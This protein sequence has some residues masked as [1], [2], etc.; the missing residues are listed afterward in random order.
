MNATSTTLTTLPLN[1]G[2]FELYIFWRIIRYDGTA[3]LLPGVLFSVVCWL[4]ENSFLLNWMSLLP[5]FGKSL[6]Y[7][8]C[9]AYTF[10]LSNQ[11]LGVEEDRKNNKDRPLPKGEISLR[12]AWVRWG[13][14]MAVY[15]LVGWWLDVLLWTLLWQAISIVHNLL[16]G[17][18]LWFIKNLCNGLGVYVSLYAAW[19]IAS[20][21][22]INHNDWAEHTVWVWIVFL[23]VAIFILVPLQDLRDMKGD[24][25][26]GRVTFPMWFGVAWTRRFLALGFGVLISITHAM[27][28][29]FAATGHVRWW[30]LLDT[31]QA[32]LGGLIAIRVLVLV[33]EKEDHRTYLLFPLWFLVMVLTPFGIV[34]WGG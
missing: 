14:G 7:F 29:W 2:A 1:R 4:G 6:L 27:L 32:A 9:F 22:P 21:G 17:S 28:M 34:R 15:F 26:S 3:A 18:R 19:D 8:A 5:V 20:P 10:C 11:I 16:G 25:L 12:G 24:E 23:S 30:L 33:N 13:L 31:A